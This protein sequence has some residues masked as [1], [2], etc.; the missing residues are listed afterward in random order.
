MNIEEVNKKEEIIQR[1]EKTK[2][3]EG[4]TILITGVTQKFDFIQFSS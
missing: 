1:L 3:F 2:I 4:Q